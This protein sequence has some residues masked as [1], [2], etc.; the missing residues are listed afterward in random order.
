MRGDVDCASGAASTSGSIGVRDG[1]IE[2]AFKEAP[3]DVGGVE[4]VADVLAGHAEVR[5]GRGAEIAR[6]VGIVDVGE[7]AL[8]VSDDGGSD[9]EG[10]DDAVGLAGG[11]VDGTRSRGAEG[12]TERGVVDGVGLRVVPHGGDGVA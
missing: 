9:I 1:E 11:E 6:R 12:G 5:G 3:G 8:T 4:Q 7:A 2:A 10:V